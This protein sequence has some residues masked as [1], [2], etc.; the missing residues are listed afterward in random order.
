[1]KRNPTEEDGGRYILY[2]MGAV[3]VITIV[4]RYLGV[5]K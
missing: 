4:L 3:A 5:V 1:M 2:M